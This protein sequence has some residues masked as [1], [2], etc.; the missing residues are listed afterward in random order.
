[1]FQNRTL[2]IATKH[3]KEQVIAPIFEA[4]LGVQCLVNS[5][6]DTDEL[7]TFSGERERVLDPVATLRAKCLKAMELHQCDLAIASEGSFGPHPSMFFIPCG[8][9]LM[10]LLD[11]KNNLEIIARKLSTETNFNEQELSDY[12]ALLAF[13][14]QVDFPKH[15]LILR[16]SKDDYSEII[17]GITD[18]EVLHQSFEKL[19]QKNNKVYAATDMRA[20]YNPTRM[21]VIEKTA[22]E[23]LQKIQSCCPQCH[24]PGFA[25]VEVQKGLPC[26]LC[27]LATQS[28]LSHCYGCQHCSYRQEKIYPHNKTS[29]DPMYCDFCNP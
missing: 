21:K 13:A 19:T 24:T 2:L 22:Q 1:M 4:G 8:D 3:K 18:F 6:L 23:L 28:T 5:A 17:K 26:S 11:R 16:A 7:G 12:D 27:G 9:E 10:M 20:M 25:V 29:E 15:G 14:H